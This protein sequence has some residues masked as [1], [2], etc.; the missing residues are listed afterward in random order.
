M[1]V[2]FETSEAW[3]SGPSDGGPDSVL[4][5]PGDSWGRN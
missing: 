2:T 1:E 5:C 3:P 4:S